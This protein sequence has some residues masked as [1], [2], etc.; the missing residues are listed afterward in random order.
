M[1][2]QHMVALQGNLQFDGVS[3]PTDKGSFW[4]VATVPDAMYSKVG[5]RT[6]CCAV[7]THA[8]DAQS[9][10]PDFAGLVKTRLARQWSKYDDEQQV[11]KEHPQTLTALA[12]RRRFD[13]VL[14]AHAA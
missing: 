9:S 11:D 13:H 4:F 7:R 8:Y 5:T 1:H 2:V 3:V 10:S 14:P 6:E 12:L